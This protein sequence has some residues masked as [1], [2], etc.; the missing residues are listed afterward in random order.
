MS[1]HL[2]CDRVAYPIICQ[3]PIPRF[4]INSDINFPS[5]P[6]PRFCFFSSKCHSFFTPTPHQADECSY[7]RYRFCPC[8]HLYLTTF[9]FF[10]GGGGG[11]VICGIAFCTHLRA[12]P[13]PRHQRALPVEH[14]FDIEKPISHERTGMVFRHT[15]SDEKLMYT[16]NGGELCGRL[17]NTDRLSDKQVV[18]DT[19]T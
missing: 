18:S 9:F 6:H 12:P 4:A 17:H 8:A 14:L 11:G 10:L 16:S 3:C 15:S 13:R 2:I 7:L 1:T 19:A 5:L